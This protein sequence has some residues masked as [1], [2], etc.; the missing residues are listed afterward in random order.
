MI[1]AVLRTLIK[2]VIEK[3]ID[4]KKYTP[5]INYLKNKC[6]DER[7]SARDEL[8]QIDTAMLPSKFIDTFE[9]LAKAHPEAKGNVFLKRQINNWR[10]IKN[11]PEGV[12]VKDLKSLDAAIKEYVAN[13]ENHFLF[14]RSPDGNM[15]PYLIQA[16]RYTPATTIQGIYH[17]AYTTLTLM[18]AFTYSTEKET[19]TFYKRDLKGGQVVRNIL[20]SMGYYRETAELIKDYTAEM[21]KFHMYRGLIGEQFSGNG[22]ALERHSYNYS[23]LIPLDSEGI[24]SKLVIDVWKEDYQTHFVQ[25]EILWETVESISLKG[26]KVKGDSLSRADTEVEIERW[27][28]DSRQLFGGNIEDEESDDE[29]V[30]TVTVIV[31][32]HPYL[33]VFH[34]QEHRYVFVHVNNIEPYKY[35]ASVINKLILPPAHKELINILVQGTQDIME[36]VIRGK[37]GGIIV[38]ATGEPGVGKTLTAEAYSEIIRRPLYSVQSSQLGI[39]LDDLEK[40]LKD[41][42]LRATRFKAIL[43][44]DECDVYV[45][46]RGDSLLQNAVVGVFLRVLE[47]Y[48]GVLFMT[49]NKDTVLDDAILSRCTAHIRYTR[50]SPSNLEAIWHVLNTQ[51]EAGISDTDIKE[52]C[53]L[54]PNMTGRSVKSAIKLAKLI[55]KRLN[56]TADIELISYVSTFLDFDKSQKPPELKEES[57]IFNVPEQK[58]K[59]AIA[60]V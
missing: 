16:V 42:L 33:Y 7:W 38:M 30:E 20:E 25:S 54:Y 52:A 44:I 9:K 56:K 29:D 57:S 26:E 32:M 2:E 49:S 4:D 60:G 14:K 13:T 55:G 18:H 22:L 59:K 27:E 58:K 12:V 36:D 6:S 10:K 21:K 24:E 1:F 11:N 47:Y 35:D 41:I 15:L 40:N 19:V 23:N 43:L 39:D 46:E 48:K 5:S 34:L 17:R 53:K 37:S 50:H 51:F 28:G 45:H 3:H 8:T 31:P